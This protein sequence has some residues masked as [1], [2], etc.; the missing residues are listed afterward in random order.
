MN[1]PSLSTAGIDIFAEYD[2]PLANAAAR[3]GLDLRHTLHYEQDAYYRDEIE[4]EPS[5]DAA[6]FL[7][8]NRTARSLPDLKA[9][10]F[11]EYSLDAH[12]L[13]AYINYVTSYEDERPDI[14]A[15]V[16]AQTTLDLHY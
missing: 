2:L 11:G 16:D 8:V 13:L 7:N 1:G 12:N 9:R 4:I 14:D 5:Y 10:L 15:E 6:G 3:F